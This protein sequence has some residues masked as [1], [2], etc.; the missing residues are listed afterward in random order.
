MTKYD[1]P[2][3]VE[4]EIDG[5]VRIIRL[6]RPDNLNATNHILHKGLAQ[7]FPQLDNDAGST[8]RRAHR[9]RAGILCRW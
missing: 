6:N 4:V 1:L 2:K 3:E 8:R 5:P 9:Q 7:V